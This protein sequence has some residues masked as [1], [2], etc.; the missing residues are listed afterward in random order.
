LT[1]RHFLRFVEPCKEDTLTKR[2]MLYA[3]CEAFEEQLAHCY[4]TLHDRFIAKPPVAKFWA[5]TAMEELQHSSILRFC[6]ERGIVSNAGIDFKAMDHID[7]LLEAV[8]GI[9]ADP[10]VSVDEAFFASLLM[11]SSELDEVYAELTSALAKDHRTLFESVRA[12]L[13]SHHHKFAGAVEE[14]CGD[15]G[16]A[17]AFRNLDASAQTRRHAEVI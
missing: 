13:R 4:F 12:S 7:E 15:R 17:Q 16:M 9:A 6:R 14:F 10:E 3:K 1:E 2:Q 5:E 8:K 11:E